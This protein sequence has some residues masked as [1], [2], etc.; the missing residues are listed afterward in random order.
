M[1]IEEALDV[2]YQDFLV[3]KRCGIFEQRVLLELL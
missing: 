3:M 2:L 1:T